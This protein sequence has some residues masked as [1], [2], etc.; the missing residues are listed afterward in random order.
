M[1]HFSKVREVNLLACVHNIYA[2]T[3]CVRAPVPFWSR[4]TPS[5]CFGG[6]LQAYSL[7]AFYAIVM[8]VFEGKKMARHDMAAKEGL[9]AMTSSNAASPT[10]A[11]QP[12]PAAGNGHRASNDAT[13]PLLAQSHAVEGLESGSHSR[14]ASVGSLG[15]EGR[16]R[17]RRAGQQRRQRRAAVQQQHAGTRPWWRFRA[18]GGAPR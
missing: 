9:S 13:E 18:R 5:C 16:R 17:E 8:F 2:C 4:T 1:I 10:P 14:Q 12:Q 7:V 15:S 11:A 6:S 3:I